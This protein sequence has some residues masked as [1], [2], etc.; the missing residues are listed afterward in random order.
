MKIERLPKKLSAEPLIDAVCE[1]RFTPSAPASNILTGLL[2]KELGGAENVRLEALP[3]SQIPPEIR[4]SDPAFRS[5]PLMRLVWGNISVGISDSS[6]VISVIG[7]YPGWENFKPKIL[8][9]AQATVNSGILSTI[10]R[11]SIKYVD[12]IQITQ[13]SPTGG[14]DLNIRVGNYQI[15]NEVALVRIEVPD[16]PFLHII[17]T[18]TQAEAALASGE[19]RSGSLVDVDTISISTPANPAEFLDSLPNNL[20]DAHKKNKRIFFECLTEE[21]L[22]ALGPEYE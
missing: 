1:I 19:K 3:A 16:T 21:T 4:N 8:Q 17:Q 18:I 13:P 10:D 9:V 22:N 7:K 14:L 2:F 20:E 15:A 6:I 12:I 11:Y 5:T